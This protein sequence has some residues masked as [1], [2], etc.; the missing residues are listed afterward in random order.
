MAVTQPK[1]VASPDEAGLRNLL[2]RR[3]TVIRYLLVASGVIRDPIVILTILSSLSRSLLM[4]SVNETARTADEGLGWSAVVLVVAAL[5]MLSIGHMNRVRAH[6]LIIKLKEDLR[7]RMTRGLLRANIE[8]LLSG[9][10]GQVYSVITTET[11]E[12]SGSIINLIEAV[13]AILIVSI[14][15][16]Y[17]F[18]ISPYAGFAAVAAICIG[19]TGY[20]VFDQPAR[21][22]MV[23]TSRKR[24]EFNDRVQD[25]LAGWKEVRLRDTRRHALEADTHD[26]IREL[27]ASANKTQELYSLGTA[28]GQA[29]TIL[30]LCFVVII[31][32][33]MAGGGTEVMFQVLTV[34]FLTSGPIEHLFSAMTRMSRAENAYYRIRLIESELNAAQS[35]VQIG[36]VVPREQFQTIELRNAMAR[37]AEAGREAEEAFVLG[38]INLSFKPGETVFICGGNGSG[39][40][41]LLSLLTG[42]RNPDSGEI[43][44]DGQP[45]TPETKA[46]FRELFSGVFSGFHLFERTFGLTDEEVELL[47]ERIVELQLA[48][49]V[50][51]HEDRFSTLS[52]SAGQS[53]RLALAVALAESR[54]IIVLDEFAADQDPSNR[55]FFYDVLVP[56][57]AAGGQLVIAVTHDDH[58][59]HKCDRLIKMEGGRIVSDERQNGSGA[60]HLP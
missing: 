33:L 50:S 60:R 34:V 1:T 20:F 17:L 57:L 39:K 42:L 52:L 19:G 43:L 6:R 25:M 16:P 21:R 7:L 54:P 32:P 18:W 31:V 4:F 48:D 26:V 13:E 12:V 36:S 11:D 58:Q 45:L 46:A 5:A 24:A 55:A 38:P 56:E 2:D 29:S 14:A 8:F 3:A 59:F 47:Q 40:T 35:P 44:L 10:H 37:V 27:G 15:V 9:R 23:I 53:R 30:L 41:T 51:L 28:Y 22:Q 49:R